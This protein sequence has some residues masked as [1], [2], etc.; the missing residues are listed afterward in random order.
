LIVSINGLF[1]SKNYYILKIPI[2]AAIGFLKAVFRSKTLLAGGDSV[3]R[4]TVHHI[5]LPFPSF[6]VNVILPVYYPESTGVI[7]N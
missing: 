4:R 6:S 2:S 1:I 3:S 5:Y 7:F